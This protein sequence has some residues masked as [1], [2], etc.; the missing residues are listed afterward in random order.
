MA[1][2]KRYEKI[3]AAIMYAT[4]I[5]DLEKLGFTGNEAIADADE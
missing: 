2:T 3:L 4:A 5:G 1:F